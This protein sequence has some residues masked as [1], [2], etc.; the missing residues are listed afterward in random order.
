MYIY[1]YIYIVNAT[2]KFGLGKEK[3]ENAGTTP[4]DIVLHY[5]YELKPTGVMDLRQ[6]IYLV[7]E[8]LEFKTRIYG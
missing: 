1:I 7:F 2:D 3:E 8:C 4:D 6:V 5:K